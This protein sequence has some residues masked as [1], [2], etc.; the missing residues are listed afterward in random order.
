M[1]SRLAIDGGT[2][3]RSTLLPYARQWVDDDDIH[4]VTSVLRSD[5]LTTGPMVG[6]FEQACAA[7]VGTREAVAVSSGTAALHAA[8]YGAGIGHED[9]VIVSTM[10]FPA[11]ANAAVYLQATPVFADVDKGTLL[12]DPT[13]VERLV[14]KKT[15]AVVA[16]DYAG[17]PC[18]YDALR[19][20]TDKHG[21]LLIADACHALGGTY[22]ERAVGSLA[23]LSTFSFHPVKP[24]ATGEGGMI[25]TDDVEMARQMRFFRNHGITTDHR[26]RHE[27]GSWCFEMLN[28]GNNYR[29]SD[30]HCALGISQLNKVPAWTEHRQMLAKRYDEGLKTMKGVQSLTMQ[31]GISHTYHLYVVQLELEQL[32]EDRNRIFEALRAENIGVNVHF[33][34]VHFHPYY[35]QTF[36]TCERQCPIAEKAYERIL[37]LPMYAAMTEDDVD[38]VIEALQ[39]VLTHY[40]R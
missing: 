14:T 30:I 23:E 22:R 25:T 11:T 24:I 27:Q 37:S 40:T 18:D 19:A 29:L 21:L 33:I 12:I 31:S 9:E 35:R 10:T 26:Q 20:I 38:D 15:K 6:A 3:V 16:T 39:K 4:A 34:P 28:L 5:W 7:F 2:P 32:R 36:R 8:Y 1:E 13:S 17:Q